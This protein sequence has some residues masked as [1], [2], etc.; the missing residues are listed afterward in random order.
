MKSKHG[1]SLVKLLS[2]Y[3]KF[4]CNRSA[5]P[6]YVTYDFKTWSNYYKFLICY[7][8]ISVIVILFK[9]CI[10][11]KKVNSK[12]CFNICSRKLIYYDKMDVSKV[13]NLHFDVCETLVTLQGVASATSQLL[14]QIRNRNFVIYFYDHTRFNES[15]HYSQF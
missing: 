12:L 4:C 6:H 7:S 13:R 5:K 2:L 15:F 11:F 3:N 9:I 8:N 14:P 1:C 10:M